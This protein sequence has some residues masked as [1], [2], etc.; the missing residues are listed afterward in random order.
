MRLR[1]LLL[2]RQAQLAARRCCI[3]SRGLQA[4]LRTRMPRQRSSQ[5]G[6]QRVMQLRGVRRGWVLCSSWWRGV[7]LRLLR[8]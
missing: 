5:R 4:L 8:R 7:L 2:L 3:S 6:L 1:Q